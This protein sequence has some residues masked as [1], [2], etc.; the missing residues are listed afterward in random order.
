MNKEKLQS[1]FQREE[2]IRKQWQSARSSMESLVQPV[3]DHYQQCLEWWNENINPNIN[4]IIVQY[5]GRS[6]ELI[7]PSIGEKCTV[8]SYL[9]YGINFKEI[10]T[11]INLD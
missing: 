2:L 5:E 9:P 4:Q 3:Q 1:L 11:I 7:R 6:I 10:G 8:E